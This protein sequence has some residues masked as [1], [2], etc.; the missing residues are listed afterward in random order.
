MSKRRG[1][2]SRSGKRTAGGRLISATPF[3][4]GTPQAQARHELFGDNGY[5][6]IGRAY[7]MGLLGEG[8]QAKDRLTIGRR[9][10]Q[11]Y[12]AEYSIGRY[13]CALD[14]T[15]R[16]LSHTEGTNDRREWVDAQTS[17]LDALGLR[18]WFEQLVD[19]LNIHTDRSPEWLGRMIDTEIANR[20]R[21]GARLLH[22]E[23][24][25]IVLR[26]ALKA[27]DALME[28]VKRVEATM[29]RAA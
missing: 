17:R 13:R 9:Y 18:P 6:A 3:D 20:G 4:K 16:G 19:P 21:K 7:A 24:D 5:D 22:D 28:P 29:A 26:A 23:R 11:A 14:S 15:V 12:H 25:F 1:R 2:P 8:D 10:A 27:L